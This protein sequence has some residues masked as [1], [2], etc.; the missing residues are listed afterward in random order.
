MSSTQDTSMD[1]GQMVSSEAKA[2]LAANDLDTEFENSSSNEEYNTES[3]LKDY[4]DDY[5]D[6][7]D[8][9]QLSE[10]ALTA[11]KP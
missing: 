6:E 4:N 11:K 3:P 7:E 9:I 2:A 5:P 10:R 8:P 1:A